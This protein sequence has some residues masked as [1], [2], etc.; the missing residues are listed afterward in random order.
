MV[1]EFRY[2]AFVSYSHRDRTWGQWLFKSIEGYSIPKHLIGKSTREGKIPR[3][4]RPLFRDREELPATDNL[5]MEIQKAL[6]ASEYLIVLCSKES[7]KSLWVSRE[8]EEFITCRNRKNILCL[9][10][11]GEPN[12]ALSGM[13][14][15]EECF[16]EPL[17]TD[18]V[19]S[20]AFEPIAAD[21]REGRDGKRLAL[22][23]IISG[24]IGV[25]LDEVIR[26]D[27]Q[28][29]YRRV[30]AIT[31]L[32]LLGVLIMGFLTLMAI[33]GRQEAEQRRTEAE[34]LIE[35]MLTDLK[36]KLEPVA[37]LDILN[38]VGDKVIS[39]YDNQ[40]LADISD[41]SLGRRARALHILGE[42]DFE[43]GNNDSALQRFEDASNATEKLLAR[44]PDN[45]NRIFEHAQS[46]FWVGF[47]HLKEND[48]DQSITSFFHYKALADQLVKQDPQNSAWQLEL[49]YALSNIG[50]LYLKHMGKADEAY[51]I[52]SQ[53][54]QTR[55]RLYG[56]TPVKSRDILNLENSYGWL[57][58]AAKITRHLSEAKKFRQKQ[59]DLLHSAIKADPDNFKIKG[60]LLHSI[61]GMAKLE[62][63]QGQPEKAIKR[64]EAAALE[65]E[66]LLSYD[67]ENKSWLT[68]AARHKLYLTEAH[69][70]NNEY[71]QAERTLVVA[72]RYIKQRTQKA[73][74]SLVDQVRLND[75]YSL[76]NAKLF[77]LQSQEER[78]LKLLGSLIDRMEKHIDTEHTSEETVAIFT[79]AHLLSGKIYANLKGARSKAQNHFLVVQKRLSPLKNQL[80]PESLNLLADALSE[81]GEIERA[82][83]I[84]ASL[85]E[86]G[87]KLS[88]FFNNSMN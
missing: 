18:G 71:D 46:V 7:A 87:F 33:E 59:I 3:H 31:G 5:S 28:K 73:V 58:D 9:I 81:L 35:F 52:F 20:T 44:A 49:S 23:K 8:I 10:L 67:P 30:T 40:K 45:T 19:Q 77:L 54:V 83:V 37:R 56:D 55:T 62:M 17:R 43:A 76:L 15:S 50:T 88:K 26:R 27:L 68:T 29:K 34:G 22:L 42:N 16:P 41:E 74:L 48:Y 86:R 2:K 57:A 14:I 38:S 85:K 21:V 78:A 60:S 80:P 13:D 47:V 25:G 39:Y 36:E 51:D 4:L 72:A 24:M 11:D 69:I 70:Q 75:H 63:A 1:E 65:A 79:C 82:Q 66:K 32:S 61:I 6:S 12:A 64:L 53:L 84:F